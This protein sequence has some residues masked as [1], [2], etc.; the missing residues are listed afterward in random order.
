MDLWIGRNSD[1]KL[2]IRPQKWTNIGRFL[3]GVKDSTSDINVR[4]IRLCYR[5]LPVIL[6]LANRDIKK[7]EN[8]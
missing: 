2:V 1:E 3:N 7:G 5:G 6:L 8:L 4:S